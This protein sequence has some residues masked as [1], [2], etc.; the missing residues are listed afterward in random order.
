MVRRVRPDGHDRL[1]VPRDAA[2]ARPAAGP[3]PTQTRPRPPS[4]RG[5]RCRPRRGGVVAGRPGAWPRPIVGGAQRRDRRLAPD[6]S[7]A[8][9]DGVVLAFVLDST[10]ALVTT[11]GALVAHAV[12]AGATRAGQ[13]RAALSERRDR[14]V[15]V[16]ATR[17]AAGS[18]RPSAT[19]SAAPGGPPRTPA[20]SRTTNTSTSGRR[21][22]SVRCSRWCTAVWTV[23]GALPASS[24]GWCAA[25][26]SGCWTVVDTTAYYSQPV[27]VVGLQPGGPVA[28]AERRS[29]S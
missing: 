4:W 17:C 28:T 18:C 14:H 29:P 26:G 20:S 5:L 8:S 25:A 6:L 2:P 9:P 16:A 3:R 12:A 27:R 19:S 10:W 23:V 15:Y 24:S 11:A 22:G 13:L 7:V 1:A 21:A